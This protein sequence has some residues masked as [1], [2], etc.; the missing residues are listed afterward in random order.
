MPTKGF[1][2]NKRAVAK[3]AREMNQELGKAWEKEQRRRPL[4]TGIEVDDIGVRGTTDDVMGDVRFV[5]IRFLDFLFDRRDAA[6]LSRGRECVEAEHDHG[7][8]ELLEQHLPDAVQVLEA[9]GLVDV[10]RALGASD[11]DAS[12]RLTNHGVRD[13]TERKARRHD[14]AMRVRACREGLLKHAYEA[15]QTGRALQLSEFASSL[16]GYFDGDPYSDE[17][18]AKAATYLAEH[19]FVDQEASAFGIAEIVRVRQ[20]GIDCVENYGGSMRAYADH[21]AMSG[22]HITVSGDV[23]GQL[24]V[25]SGDV[26]QIQRQGSD[27][28][29]LLVFAHALRE[30]AEVVGLAPEQASDITAVASQ[31]EAE[32][33]KDDPDQGWI[34][35]LLSR[36]KALLGKAEQAKNLAQLASLAVDLYLKTNAS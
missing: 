9:Q 34:K 29:V 28:D 27:S 19:D 17:E 16:G 21:D 22:M 14:V 26:N 32:A 12:V 31:I 1:K 24:A 10:V 35:G 30:I 13:V 15:L 23:S 36:A 2:I 8:R 25:A 4:R 6:V 11:L 5:A 33:N 20:R 18:I 7:I 3:L